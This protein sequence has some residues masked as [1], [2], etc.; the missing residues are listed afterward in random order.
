MGKH[1]EKAEKGPP[2]PLNIP[3]QPI[4]ITIEEEP[5]YNKEQMRSEFK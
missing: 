2:P 4:D 5:K 1:K 3:T